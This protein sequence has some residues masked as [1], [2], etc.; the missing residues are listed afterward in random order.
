[1]SGD[2]QDELCVALRHLHRRN[3]EPSTRTIGKSIGYSHATVAYTL[4]GTRPVTWVVVEAIVVHLGGDVEY[5]RDLWIARRDRED[6]LPP[7]A[8]NPATLQ[9][10][11]PGGSGSTEDGRGQPAV[12]QA[13]DR[14]EVRG[15]PGAPTVKLFMPAATAR[16]LFFG[17]MP[18]GDHNG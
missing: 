14:V 12:T 9:A 1:V 10:T 13:D 17:P 7:L 11:K 18:Q 8:G 6:P 4:N 15:L 16:E 3:G 2:A 5:F